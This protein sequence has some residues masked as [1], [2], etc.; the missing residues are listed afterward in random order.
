MKTLLIT[1]DFPPLIGGVANYYF[2]RVKVMAGKGDEM[3]VLAPTFVIP[4][5]AGIQARKNW[6]RLHEN[7]DQVGDDNKEIKIYRKNFFTN[8]FWPHWLPLIWQIY[9][10]VKKEKINRLWVGQILPVGTAVWIVC[11]FCN[12]FC[13][14]RASEDPLNQR[15]SRF[16]GNDIRK[17]DDKKFSFFITCHGNDLLRAKNNQRKFKIAKRI[18]R[19]AELVEANTEFTKNILIND[20]DI[21]LEKIKIVYPVNTLT[22]EMV[23]QKKVS[24]LKEKYNLANKKVLLTVARLVES[25][26]IDKVIQALPKVF[27][28]IPDLVYLIVGNGPYQSELL[29]ISA[30]SSRINNKIIF[31]GSVPHE[32]LPNYYALANTFILNPRNYAGFK[33]SA[34]VLNGFKPVP[35]TESFGIVYLEAKE[36]GL[37]IIAGNVG[38]A[39]EIAKN[40][41]QMHLIDSENQEEIIEKIIEIIK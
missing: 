21:G 10:I 7:G 27:E 14:P 32:E 23:D 9:K 15:D 41:N 6:I 31:V 35:D 2:N 22:R 28:K 38:G 18:L 3:A 17:Q 1:L 20:F 13:H 25:K 40:Y 30:E 19:D 8:F 11:K 34:N 33:I 16:R 4:A 36:F 26:G 12:L 39:S 24:E 5:Q 37:P 29:R